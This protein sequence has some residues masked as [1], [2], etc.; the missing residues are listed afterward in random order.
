MKPAKI[1]FILNPV[2][3]TNRQRK[4]LRNTLL[5]FCK[6]KDILYSL[7]VIEEPGQG[8]IL[9][10]EA[11]RQG[12][13]VIV[14]V[15]G[16]GTVNDVAKGVINTSVSL[17][18]IPAGSGNG[19]ARGIGIPL[20]V[21]KACSC[22]LTSQ[23][24][25]ID[26]GKVNGEYFFNIAGL[27]L[28]A[29]LA[30]AYKN[31]QHGGQRGIAPYFFLSLSEYRRF[32][33]AEITLRS[34]DASSL[35]QQFSP[36]LIAVANGS[37]YGGGVK[38]AP[39][40]SLYDGLF[41]VVIIESATWAQI[42][43]HLPKLFNGNFDSVPFSRTLRVPELSIESHRDIIYHVDGEVRSP[44]RQLHISVCPATLTVL[45]PLP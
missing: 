34:H 37:Q 27:G 32:Q 7:R 16:D 3:G 41:D 4:S 45:A 13:D 21:K 10:Q 23:T 11:V 5:D 25:I 12:Y 39:R 1:A 43:W 17:G 24:M 14:A 15:G 38:I 22:L 18:V 2:G 40:A 35:E 30:V 31:K 29:N 28:D 26:A 8:K 36:V 6:T 33:P 19:F 20:D 9:A 42:L 44:V